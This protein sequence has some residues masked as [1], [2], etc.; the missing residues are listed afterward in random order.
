MAVA[1]GKFSLKV[2]IKQN[3]SEPGPRLEVDGFLGTLHFLFTPQQ[4][5]LFQ[6]MATDIVSQGDFVLVTAD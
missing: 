5:R 3:E 6:E 2:T 1:G 4:I